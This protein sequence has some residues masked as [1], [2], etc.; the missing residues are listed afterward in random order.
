MNKTKI[1]Y[2]VINRNGKI[3]YYD[4]FSF[5]T[6]VLYNLESKYYI[7]EIKINND[8]YDYDIFHIDIFEDTKIA[9]SFSPLYLKYE[10]QNSIN[11]I[12]RQPLEIFYRLELL[13]NKEFLFKF[14]DLYPNF[15]YTLAKKEYHTYI[16]IYDILPLLIKYNIY[17]VRCNSSELIK[18]ILNKDQPINVQ[19]YFYNFFKKC[20]YE[21]A[22]YTT[23]IDCY[24]E[25]IMYND[26]YYPFDEKAENFINFITQ[27][28]TYIYNNPNFINEII[29]D[30]N[31]SLT[32]LNELILYLSWNLYNFDFNKIYAFYSKLKN[33][34]YER[35]LT[36][37]ENEYINNKKLDYQLQQLDNLFMNKS[38]NHTKIINIIL[39]CIG[40][41]NHPYLLRQELI[42]NRIPDSYLE[43]REFLSLATKHK[44]PFFLHSTS[45]KGELEYIY[46]YAKKDLEILNLVDPETFSKATVVLTLRNICPYIL[47]YAPS[48]LLNDEYF[49]YE[50]L[51]I[52]PIDKY[53]RLGDILSKDIHFIKK[54]FSIDPNIIFYCNPILYNKEELMEEIFFQNNNLFF[55]LSNR[56]KSKYK[57]IFCHQWKLYQK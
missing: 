16:S 25:S 43:N 19:V 4:N 24:I 26:N 37:L 5:D 21:F 12:L 50:Y 32:M 55:L 40:L 56:L 52:Y 35:E 41:S 48:F 49:M 9:S 51:S 33:I 45:Y 54:A 22:Y 53:F 31:L 11:N 20:L 28:C 3:F 27:L 18:L 8:Y 29:N 15:L 44:I 42:N 39:K 10:N 14:I 30:H 46:E 13:K 57:H 6:D 1:A 47:F 36:E 38:Q 7:S 17:P 2:K 23:Y 34:Y